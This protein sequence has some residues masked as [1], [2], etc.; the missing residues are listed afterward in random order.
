MFPSLPGCSWAVP[1]Q[2]V[3]D[4]SPLPLSQVHLLARG[5]L[6]WLIS[7][8]STSSPQGRSHGGGGTARSNHLPELINW[9]LQVLSR[10]M[11]PS[12]ILRVFSY[13]YLD[14]FWIYCFN[15]WRNQQL[16]KF[17]FCLILCS[18]VVVSYEFFKQHVCGFPKSELFFPGLCFDELQYRSGSCWYF[19]L[20]C[21]FRQSAD[22]KLLAIFFVWAAFLPMFVL[23]AKLS[24]QNGGIFN[25]R[26]FFRGQPPVLCSPRPWVELYILTLAEHVNTPELFYKLTFD[27]N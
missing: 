5:R 21:I 22:S 6:D 17:W 1:T 13:Y 18:V 4:R 3:V 23:S 19:P 25:Y 16:E 2:C 20:L 12:C 24:S 7:T 10:Q 27:D 8:D 26:P 11:H 15:S 9:P 14:S